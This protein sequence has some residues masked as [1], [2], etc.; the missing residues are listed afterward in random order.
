MPIRYFNKFLY[1]M[2]LHGI[3][4]YSPALY[5]AHCS[6]TLVPTYS[7]MS[8]TRLRLDAVETWDEIETRSYHGQIMD[9]PSAHSFARQNGG[10]VCLVSFFI[11][12]DDQPTRA[13]AK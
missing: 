3:W 4:E 1:P 5:S 7:F 8:T 2:Y 12:S 10:D 11:G 6:S 9:G 13:H